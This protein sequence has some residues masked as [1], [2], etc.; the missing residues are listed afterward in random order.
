MLRIDE[1]FPRLWKNYVYQSLFAAL[2]LFVVMLVLKMGQAVVIASIG[3]TAFIIFAMP[4]SEA[5]NPRRVI[6]G[7]IVGFIS[8]TIFS[9]IVFDPFFFTAL[10]YSL[11]VAVALFTMVITDTEHP[12]AAGTALGIAITGFSWDAAMAVIISVLILSLIHHFAKPYI[13]D[14]V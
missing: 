9:V 13:K 3:A 6:G 5:A 8:G 11:A 4:N 1:K 14:L 2:A 12:P 7:H 10:I